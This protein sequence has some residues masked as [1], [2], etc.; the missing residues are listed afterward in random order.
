MTDPVARATAMHAIERRPELRTEKS[1]GVLRKALK[2]NLIEKHAA[3]KVVARHAIGRITA[4]G[5]EGIAGRSEF[6]YIGR[7]S[8]VP[9][10]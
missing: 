2:G 6:S 7:R 10:G 8:T 3:L 1:V 9:F 5:N 4:G